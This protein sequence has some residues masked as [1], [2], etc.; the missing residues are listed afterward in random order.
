[1]IVPDLVYRFLQLN[2]D[3]PISN[4]ALVGV[5]MFSQAFSFNLDQHQFVI[6][7]NS[8]LEDFQKDAFAYQ[9]F[10]SPELPIPKVIQLGQFNETCYFVITQR[11]RGV[12]LNDLEKG[13]IER[14]LPSLFNTL[15]CIHRLNC[16]KYLGW[17]LTDASGNGRFTSWQEYL[18]SFYHQKFS[19]TWEQLFR[20]TLMEQ[21]LYEKALAVI[22][23]NLQ[24]CSTPKYWV[25]GDFGFDNVIS[26]G[27]RIT[28]VR[29][30]AES[31]L[32]DFVYDIAYLDFWS[33]DIFYKQRW[34]EW[35][36]D[37]ATGLSLEYFEERF[38]CYLLHIGLKGLA[39]AAIQ[40]DL[41]DYTL[42]K[43]KIQTILN[44]N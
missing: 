9:T 28:G 25:H 34:Q 35:I 32:G 19:F 20:G 26:D 4:V 18:L 10:V 21:D 44:G 6:R 31:L 15:H 33:D 30:W 13:T 36:R 42:V 27:R 17:G 22:Q 2:F 39:I 11:C 40:N 23:H 3:S 7:F 37:R 41:E 14:I 5:G 16:S 29:D 8:Y 43:A 38:R 24:F 12:T 1:M